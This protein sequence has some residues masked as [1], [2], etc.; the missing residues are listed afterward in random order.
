MASLG[1][2]S[3]TGSHRS[4]SEGSPRPRPLR[5][6]SS[7]GS[8]SS[9]TSSSEGSPRLPRLTIVSSTGSVICRLETRFK[10][11]DRSLP[12]SPMMTR[13][14]PPQISTQE[15]Q[16]SENETE[17]ELIQELNQIQQ[18]FMAFLE[19][20]DEQEHTFSSELRR[21]FRTIIDF[22]QA[23]SVEIGNLER[24]TSYRKSLDELDKK[25][26]TPAWRDFFK[27]ISD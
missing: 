22:F 19:V 2:V 23:K 9:F 5:V 26:N 15:D 1:G 8:V 18:I 6:I 16:I 7:M 10:S 21:D 14:S 25:F 20:D 11:G 12:T 13:S 3:G 4:P 27:G 17:E 24:K